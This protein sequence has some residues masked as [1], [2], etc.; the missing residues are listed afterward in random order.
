MARR[1]EATN[2]EAGIETLMNLG[3]TSVEMLRQVGIGTAGDLREAGA[4]MAYR[5]LRHRFGK[6][7]VNALFLFAMEGALQDRHWNSFTPD[8]KAA[9]REEAS[10]DLEVG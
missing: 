10:G 8:E 9:L 2:E 7:R 4:A 5:I 1:D 6:Q 3:P